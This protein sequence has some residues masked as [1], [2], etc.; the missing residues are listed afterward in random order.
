[1]V[2]IVVD[3]RER[4]EIQYRILHLDFAVEIFAH[5]DGVAD[6]DDAVKTQSV[7]SLFSHAG[8]NA[9]SR[10]AARA[11]V[12]LSRQILRGQPAVVA[13]APALDE[14]EQRFRVLFD[15]EEILGVLR[16]E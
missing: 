14:G 10:G 13:V 5:R 16:I 1:M 11:P 3:G 12:G 8:G 6:H 4:G 2:V 7:S 9:C 15:S